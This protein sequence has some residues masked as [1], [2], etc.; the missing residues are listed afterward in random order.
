[1]GCV[2]APDGRSLPFKTAAEE[3]LFFDTLGQLLSAYSKAFAEGVRSVCTHRTA[4][5]QRGHQATP[6]ASYF[7]LRAAKRAARAT[8]EIKSR[9]LS[10]SVSLSIIAIRRFVSFW[11]SLCFSLQLP[12]L[13]PDPL[14]ADLPLHALR[15]LQP[16]LP[17]FV[18]ETEARGALRSL[19][20]H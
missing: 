12:L 15:L 2:A 7:L 20:Q 1:M 8:I 19:S 5:E 14:D 13:A 6:N 11:L 17:P 3:G 16:F 18:T 10:P 4:A 9:A